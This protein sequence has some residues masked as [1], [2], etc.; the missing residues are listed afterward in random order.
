MWVASEQKSLNPLKRVNSILTDPSR[1]VSKSLLQSLNP[2]KRVNS[3][4]TQLV[5]KLTGPDANVSI[6]SNGSIQF[7]RDKLKK[8]RKKG[9]FSLNPL[10]RVNSILTHKRLTTRY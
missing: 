1:K 10:K 5:E 8:M 4:L 9:F 3:I 6:P 7:L 2:L